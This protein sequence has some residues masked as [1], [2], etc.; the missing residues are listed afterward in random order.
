MLLD[1]LEK[2]M[3][4]DD[5]QPLSYELAQ[6]L[7]SLAAR[8]YEALRRF[9]TEARREDGGDA[10]AGECPGHTLGELA[11]AVLGPGDWAPR[12]QAWSSGTEK[13]QFQRTVTPW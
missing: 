7:V 12:P 8:D 3:R 9:C 4:P 11:A 2:F 1:Y 5:G 6:V 10:A 13:G